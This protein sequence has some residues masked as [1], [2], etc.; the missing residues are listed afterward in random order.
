MSDFS[1]KNPNSSD[2]DSFGKKKEDIYKSAQ[3]GSLNSELE[4]SLN[5]TLSKLCQSVGKAMDYM[6]QEL[7]K[8]AQEKGNQTANHQTAAGFQAGSRQSG[9][10]Q[11][12]RIPYGQNSYNKKVQN[13]TYYRNNTTA[14]NTSA[15]YRNTKISPVCCPPKS[16]IV[17]RIFGWI[18]TGAFGALE[19]AFGIAMAAT[20]GLG[21]FITFM[22]LLPFFLVGLGLLAAGHYRKGRFQR[23]KQ[24][25]RELQGRP[26]G[27]IRD[28]ARA[29]GKS[30]NYTI[31]DLRKMITDGV[32]PN[33]H[34]DD[35]ETYLMVTREVF[36]D[37]LR[38]DQ[39]RK[40]KIEEE[41]KAA[42]NAQ[43]ETVTRQTD[44]AVPLTEK[45]RQVQETVAEGRRYLE[46]IF[47]ANEALPGEAI[48]AKLDRLY[49]VTDRI[50]YSVEQQ[51]DKLGEIKQFM[52]YYLPTTLKL[53]NAYREFEDNSIQGS[54]ITAAKEEIELSLDTI[55]DGFGRLLNNLFEQDALD[56]STDIYVLQ[57]MLAREGLAE[58]PFADINPE[59]G[60][61]LG[62]NE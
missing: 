14:R 55:N 42:A 33:G 44:S 13:Q 17:M 2:A 56:I 3:N 1:Q 48:S 20:G 24:Y 15:Q 37:Y 34:L 59:E 19:L 52:K 16:G 10:N 7:E 47:Q 61:I 32:F 27:R 22:V 18:L 5:M 45:Q 49:D 26:F 50:L 25:V 31:K 38:A 35:E 53:V 11:G 41:S 62:S 46:E 28:L 36:D 60:S 30:E 12:T 39:I 4:T 43:A 51:P 40:Q 57:N 23:F 6:N 58:D 29:I 8:S 9:S 54:N 21:Y